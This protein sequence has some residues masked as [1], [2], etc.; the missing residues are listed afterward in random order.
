LLTGN[1]P[2]ISFEHRN[3]AI[4]GMAMKTFTI[5]A[6]T[7]SAARKELYRLISKDVQGLRLELGGNVELV[8]GEYVPDFYIVAYES[9]REQ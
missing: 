4:K 1:N 5:H 8:N 2:A 6:L 7:R 3:T 9:T